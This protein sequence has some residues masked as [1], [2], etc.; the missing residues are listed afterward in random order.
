MNQG[1]NDIMWRAQIDWQELI[2]LA[3]TVVQKW[4][5]VTK[6]STQTDTRERIWTVRHSS[7][8]Q[9]FMVFNSDSLRGTVPRNGN[10][11]SFLL[12]LGIAIARP[13]T[14]DLMFANGQKI[15]PSRFE[16]DDLSR[17]LPQAT[18]PAHRQLA[19][20]VMQKTSS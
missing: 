6:F 20:L 1:L 8:A 7:V 5:T 10:P 18:H 9:P 13:G 15:D 2:K 14:I 17:L 16:L 3:E 4:N 19:T 11:L 12:L